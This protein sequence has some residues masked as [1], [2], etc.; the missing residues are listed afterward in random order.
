[1][2]AAPSAAASGIQDVDE[3]GDAEKT[4]K[5]R[6]RPTAGAGEAEGGI[7]EKMAAG[8]R[9]R[10]EVDK[11]GAADKEKEMPLRRGRSSAGE[12]DFR[13]LGEEQGK[14][15]ERKK[16]EKKEK[17]AVRAPKDNEAT[18]KEQLP[19]RGWS[20]AGEA[21]LR[22]LGEG[23]Q[24]M[25]T[26]AAGL[27]GKKGRKRGRPATTETEE[28]RAG[29]SAKQL[30]A[31][32][33]GRPSSSRL[34]E[35]VDELLGEQAEEATAP[36]RRSRRSL[37]AV[38]DQAG[39]DL[40]TKD[41]TGKGKEGLLT[42]STKRGR[43][44]V[45][46]SEQPTKSIT[47]PD[48]RVVKKRGRPAAVE[49][50][51]ETVLE[52]PEPRKRRTRQPDAEMIEQPAEKLTTENTPARGRARHRRS[53]VAEQNLIQPKQPGPGRKKAVQPDIQ[54]EDEDVEVRGR[55]RARRSDIGSQQVVP[56]PVKESSSKFT[57]PNCRSE[58]VAVEFASSKLTKIPGEKR[59][60]PSSSSSHAQKG[61]S[62]TQRSAKTKKAS[63]SS[64]ATSS[65]PSQT[66]KRGPRRTS[67]GEA[68]PRKRKG[69]ESKF[70]TPAMVYVF[71]LMS[72]RYRVRALQ[73]PT[74]RESTRA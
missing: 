45:P 15:D 44:S 46:R 7:G 22:I 35:P 1:M 50:P 19:R 18:E 2:P 6:G 12:A 28:D 9:G 48:D 30:S 27:E 72:S 4:R 39:D 58:V 41:A 59:S 52:V 29:E 57:K 63:R 66:Q 38:E 16:Q 62:S 49:N 69:V 23:S 73:T 33:R 74:C 25:G 60:K 36:K 24:A 55:R 42:T 47:A 34:E 65:A 5:K 54:A 14:E 64:N 37:A 61:T 26:N 32:K 8:N 31:K 53:N 3:D 56:E 10:R 67:Q 20:S 40:G 13:A 17:K 43:P 71:L 70:R 11:I 21:E 68:P 51:A